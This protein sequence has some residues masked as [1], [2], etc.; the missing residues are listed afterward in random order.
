ML[1]PPKCCD[2][3]RGPQHPAFQTLVFLSTPL[4]DRHGDAHLESQ[5]SGPL[6][7]SGGGMSLGSRSLRAAWAANVSPLC[8]FLFY[9]KPR[10]LKEGG[11]LLC[12]NLREERPLCVGGQLA[13]L[14]I[15][16]KADKMWSPAVHP[17][18]SAPPRDTSSVK[19]PS[20]KDF[21]IVQN[22]ATSWGAQVQTRKLM[23]VHFIFTQPLCLRK[24]KANQTSEPFVLEP[25]SLHFFQ[26]LKQCPRC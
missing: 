5:Y 14:S 21:T 25:E 24:T 13:T 18:G 7:G 20:P 12:P 16:P 17:Q 9:L 11:V 3:R 22:C 4:W 8:A 1:L 10:N 6:G 15:R 26:S 23:G 19:A 2:G